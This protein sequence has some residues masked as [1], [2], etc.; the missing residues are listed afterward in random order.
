MADDPKEIEPGHWEGEYVDVFGYRATLALDLEVQGAAATGKATL[1]LL[2]DERGQTVVGSVTGKFDGPVGRL[3]ISI[4][5]VDGSFDSE[6]QLR[7]AGTHASQA[8]FGLATTTGDSGLGGGVWIVWH[9]I[10]ER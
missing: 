6:V 9:F 1:E 3:I 8:M 7:S 5:A 10:Q 2:S 4:E